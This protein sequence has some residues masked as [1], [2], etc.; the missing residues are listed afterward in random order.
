VFATERNLIKLGKQNATAA[1]LDA[2][3]NERVVTVCPEI[4]RGE[5]SRQLRIPAEAGYD[6]SVF[7]MGAA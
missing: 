1:S 6:G 2:A 4:V 5:N 3:R 7:E